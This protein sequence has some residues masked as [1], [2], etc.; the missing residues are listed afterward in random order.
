MSWGIEIA[1]RAT[2]GLRGPAESHGYAEERACLSVLPQ[3]TIHCRV[4]L[5]QERDRPQRSAVQ[6][7]RGLGRHVWDLD[8]LGREQ[9]HRVGAHMTLLPAHRA[10]GGSEQLIALEL[11]RLASGRSEIL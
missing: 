10:A 4:K 5:A 11:P 7:S 6:T 8:S 2:R 9:S 1:N 3:P